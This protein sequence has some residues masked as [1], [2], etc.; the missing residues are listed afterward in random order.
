[1]L[2]GKHKQLIKIAAWINLLLLLLG[3]SILFF[4]QNESISGS[5]GI[6]R[7]ISSFALANV[8][9]WVINL[10]ILLFFDHFIPEP[11]RNKLITF[12]FP[13]YVMVFGVALIIS[14]T[15]YVNLFTNKPL[16][17]AIFS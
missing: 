12:Y 5:A 3:M 10:S 13:S 9:C 16:S 2:S 4:L 1:M 7:K 14:H 8:I 6:T 15:P 11:K 17:S